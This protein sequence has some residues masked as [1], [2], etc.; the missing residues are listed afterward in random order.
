MEYPGEKLV[1]RLWDTLVGAGIGGLLRPWQ[2]RREGRAQIDVRR[3]AL[4]SLA[5]TERDIEEIR[6]GRK[7]LAPD[8]RLVELSEKPSSLVHRKDS[9]LHDAATAVQRN[10]I[11][12]MMREEVNVSKALL[13]AEATLEDDPQ[14]PPEQRVDDDWLFR[15]RDAASMVSSEELQTL[16]GRVLAGETK[17]PGSCSLRTLE[18]LKNLSHK[19][20]LQIAKVSPFVVENSWI[21]SGNQQLL[22]SEGINLSFLL[23]LQNL[24]I[25]S[26]VA[27][28]GLLCTFSSVESE[29]FVRG[30]VSFN[31]VLLVTHDDPGKKLSLTVYQLT[32]LGS[33]I[34]RLGS[35]SP[36]ED[37]I[38]SI[39]KSICRD[40]FKVQI[41]HYTKLT[42]DTGHYFDPQD[43]T[44]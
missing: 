37:Y 33:Q 2:D 43:L 26:G 22:D 15:W 32:E 29:K 31:R 44:C 38:R 42:E 23:Y 19:E 25:V 40:G 7:S 6:S 14:A 39:G 10:R 24:G 18:F 36:H 34:L 4:L 28:L 8:G 41:A 30:L 27:A 35:F 1:I 20:A 12:R 9:V 5:Q 17:S 13:S 16:W 21:F 3:E 11:H